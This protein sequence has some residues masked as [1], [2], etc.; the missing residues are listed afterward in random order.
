MSKGELDCK[1]SGVVYDETEQLHMFQ[2]R[3]RAI[4]VDR[5]QALLIFAAAGGAAG[6]AACGSSNNN[7]SK[8]TNNAAPKAPAANASAGAPTTAAAPGAKVL[9]P[10]PLPANVKLAANQVFRTNQQNESEP[11]SHDFNKDL[12]CG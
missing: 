6:L 2:K 9:G 8:T 12:Y 3:L 4:K 5:R 1:E 11:S 7:S 10:G